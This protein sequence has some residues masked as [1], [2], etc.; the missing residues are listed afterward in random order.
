MHNPSIAVETS[1]HSPSVTVSI[2]GALSEILSQT[3]ES[4]SYL[5]TT[6]TERS[7][8]ISPMPSTISTNQYTTDFDTTINISPSSAIVNKKKT[9]N[10]SPPAQDTNN[11]PKFS[12]ST[13]TSDITETSTSPNEQVEAFFYAN[14]K[15]VPENLSNILNINK[16]KNIGTTDDIKQTI[17]KINK[18][19]QLGAPLNNNTFNNNNNQQN[20]T[21]NIEKSAR[22]IKHDNIKQQPNTHTSPFTPATV[23]NPSTTMKTNEMTETVR[24]ISTTTPFESI[25]F[26]LTANTLNETEKPKLVNDL[27][28]PPVTAGNNK[29]LSNDTKNLPTQTTVSNEKLTLNLASSINN[30]LTITSTI[31]KP[32]TNL[33][34]KPEITNFQ[35]QQTSSTST[36]ISMMTMSDDQTTTI[37]DE[38]NFN[39]KTHQPYTLPILTTMIFT[40]TTTTPFASDPPSYIESMQAVTT[41]EPAINYTTPP[42][43]TILDFSSIQSKRV[44]SLAETYAQR[45]ERRPVFWRADMPSTPSMNKFFETTTFSPL[46]SEKPPIIVLP[47][48][49]TASTVLSYLVPV[50]SVGYPD[51]SKTTSELPKLPTIAP[52]LLPP[53][54]DSTTAY[55]NVPGTSTTLKQGRRFDF[56]V[57]GIL[58]NNTVVRKSPDDI[59]DQS[60]TEDPFFVYG[61]LSNKTVVRKYLNGTIVADTERTTSNNFEITDIDPRKLLNPNSDIYRTE[62][63]KF[64][65]E[66]KNKK[67]LGNFNFERATKSGF[68]DISSVFNSVTA[69]TVAS[70]TSLSSNSNTVNS[71]IT[72]PTM[73]FTSAT[74]ILM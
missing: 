74:F 44:A 7:S 52:T 24:F 21:I 25:D 72:V 56:V 71:T 47:T 31:T 46:N 37:N 53:M 68:G 66:I 35:M 1:H 14:K 26:T 70:T 5:T 15:S 12:L 32:S 33:L 13:A 48:K 54:P 49:E 63:S 23:T 10:E 73:V 64:A 22:S 59:Y 62:K 3:T 65:N 36:E 60:T 50:P 20:L 30:E 69:R 28:N 61:I 38:S 8:P 27:T 41:Q 39:Q 2:F 55:R 16:R 40:T 67:V 17:F 9:E 42:L 43:A 19:I 57:Y 51:S 58:P 4:L 34:L 6:T 11:Y 18:Q 29:K 45:E